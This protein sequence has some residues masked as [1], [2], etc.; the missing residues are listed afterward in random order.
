M[1]SKLLC[2]CGLHDWTIK[3]GTRHLHV[4][5]ER[6]GTRQ[7]WKD[8]NPNAGYQPIISGWERPPHPDH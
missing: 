8:A 1:I 5:C 4:E 3:H 2:R 6:C 7:I